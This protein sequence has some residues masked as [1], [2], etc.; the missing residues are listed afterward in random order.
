MNE[1]NLNLAKRMENTR[2][3]G[4]IEPP[5]HFSLDEIYHHFL[6]SMAE[7]KAQSDIADRLSESGRKKDSKTI[8]RA[9]IVISEGLL[10]FY[11]HEI[12]K[13]CLFRMFTGEWKKS[14]K[15]MNIMVPMSKVE[16][17]VMSRNSSEWF[18][19]YLNEKLSRDVYLSSESM[20]DQLNMIGI[21]FQEV[22]EKAFPCEKKEASVARG[23]QIIS[24]MFRR[25]NAIAHQNDRS[26]ASAVQNDIT[27]NFV[28]EYMHNIET[29]VGTIQHIASSK[30][31][32]SA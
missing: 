6:D 7:I 5:V 20:K 26:H 11:L 1:R 21:G 10:D 9:Q 17:G 4:R 29:V 12:S 16:Q 28:E 3:A 19:E 31:H 22:M 13:F 8:L 27:K 30:D 32:I 24:E 14:E 25:R 18:F 15:Y 2:K 23:K